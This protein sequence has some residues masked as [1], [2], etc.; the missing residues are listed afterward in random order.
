MA[1][2]WDESPDEQYWI[3]I[4]GRDDIGADLHAPSG[5]EKAKAFWSYDLIHRLNDGDIVYHYDR[6]KQAIVGYSEAVGQPWRDKIVWAAQ[7]MSARKQGILP[8]AREGFRLGLGGFT[9][10]SIPVTKEMLIA[11]RAALFAARE[12]VEKA[13]WP[14]RFPF[15]PYGNSD[16]RALQGYL[17]KLPKSLLDVLPELRITTI[18]AADQVAEESADYVTLG[19]SYRQANE[20]LAVST[21]DP[22]AVDPALVERALKGH[23]ST[24][25]ALAAF[26]ASMG[27][28]PLSPIAGGPNF[29]LAW[30]HGGEVWVAEVKSCT[31]RNQE[32]QLRLGLGQVLRYRSVL[33]R[34]L[35]RPVRTVLMVEMEPLDPSWKSL[36]DEL[37]VELR[38]PSL[39]QLPSA[40]QSL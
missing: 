28:T 29:D 8:H 6:N 19:V 31:A 33:S 13:G 10:L 1:E 12:T 9:P 40:G 17:T 35:N 27:A 37:G 36:C 7:S 25:N 20:T 4:T 22:F 39:L 18:P 15:I 30:E 14:S 3:E 11:R 34:R 38:W 26:V 2:W 23:A 32:N 16:V 5:N 24:Q 21:I